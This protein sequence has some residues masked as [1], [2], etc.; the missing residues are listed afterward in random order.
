MLVS[1]KWLRT[2]VRCD[3]PAEEIASR[4]TMAGLEVEALSGRDL[5]LSRVIVG[6]ILGISPHPRAASLRICEVDGGNRTYQVVCGAPNLAPGQTAPLALEGARLADGTEIHSAEVRGVLS[7]A[8]LCSEAELGL[9]DDAG[10][11]MNLPAGLNPGRPLV[12]ALDLADQILEVSIT[13]NRG[14]CLSVLGIAREVSALFGAPWTPPDI[15]LQETGPPVESLASVIIQDPDLCPR[16]AARVV[17]NVKVGLSPLWLRQRLQAHGIRAINCIVDVTN[18]VMLEQGQPLHAFDYDRLEGNR[19]VVRRARPGESFTTLDSQNHTLRRD[20]LLICDAARGV[21][22]AGIMGGLNSEITPETTNVLIESAYFQPIGIRRTAKALNLGS[23]SSYR[24]ERGVD[25]EGV[26]NAL[27]RAAQLMV[28]LGSG[29][30]ARGRLDVYPVPIRRQSIQLRVSKCVRFLGLDVSQAEICRL[31]AS[32]HL[33]VRII[34]DDSLEVVPPPFRSDLTREVDLME[35]VARLA[36]F[37][38]IPSTLPSALVTAT[39]PPRTQTFREVA[40]EALVGLGFS[41]T[42]SFSF[43]SR[44][45]TEKLR[46]PPDDRRFH[47]LPIRNPLT[48][49]QA[50]LRTSLIPSMLEAAARNQRQRKLNVRLFELSKVFFPRGSEELPE[51]RFNLCGLLSGTRRPASWNDPSEPVDFFDLKG[52]AEALMDRVGAS[53]LRWRHTSAVPFL[54]PEAAAEIDIAGANAG[55]L[56]EVRAEVLEA[57]EVKGPAFIVDLDFDLLEEKA[58]DRKTFRPLPRFPEVNRDLAIVVSEDLSAQRVLDF[59]AEHRPEHCESVLLFDCYRGNQV[60]AGRKSLAYRITYRSPER[61][62][63]DE[64]VNGIHTRVTEKVLAAF[65]ATLR[66]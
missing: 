59:L 62:L 22:L 6:R 23:E 20:M 53:E 10:G 18:Y 49:E 11:I 66:S 17:R 8:V 63:T 39:K 25:P 45:A 35:E 30:L 12:E 37:D 34:D 31:L 38:R 57:F 42:I 21:A 43:I 3:A 61:S 28:E 16:Y 1:L 58:T 5:G 29:E 55:V 36:G 44:Q 15:T 52:V 26:I 7:E 48:E 4:L 9:G 24:F 2:H 56:G 51:E 33:P 54:R 46:I 60:G 14:D 47:H 50:V 65:E 64:E 13:P 41:E 19:I 40:K 27:D 32:I